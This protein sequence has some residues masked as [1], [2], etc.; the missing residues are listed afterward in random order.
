MLV[1]VGPLPTAAPVT[2]PVTLEHPLGTARR[3]R[4]A[5]VG[6]SLKAAVVINNYSL[7]VLILSANMTL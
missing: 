4:R 5:Q 2:T 7:L 1:Q 3:G 6:K